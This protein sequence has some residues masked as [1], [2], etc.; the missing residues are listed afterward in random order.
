MNPIHAT[1]PTSIPPQRSEGNRGGHEKASAHEA[2]TAGTEPDAATPTAA[3][4]TQTVAAATQL[5][6][7]EL[8]QIRDLKNR[9]RE[10]RQHER[11]H[12]AAAAGISHGAP[13]Y[14]Y[15]RGPDGQMYATGGEVRIDTAPVAGDP[16][17][18]IEKAR[19]IQ[20][21]ALAPAEPSAQDRAVAAAAMAMAADARA[22][23]QSATPGNADDAAT[24]APTGADSADEAG[25]ADGP[26]DR[27]AGVDTASCA[28]CGAAHSAAEHLVTSYGSV[29]PAADGAAFRARA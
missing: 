3:T 16:Q 28:V 19:Q 7:A 17:A 13:S 26:A 24:A 1:S 2:A 25:A 14:S 12:A 18:T 6:R 10:V 27:A 29:A 5:D 22:E 11:A 21:A 20:R 4:R 8:E 15:T 9:D 23:L